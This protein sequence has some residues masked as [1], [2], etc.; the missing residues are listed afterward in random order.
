MAAAA[1]AAAAAQP[2]SG[3]LHHPIASSALA[4]S[5][6]QYAPGM[7]LAKYPEVA[8]FS[9][10]GQ[11][12]PKSGHHPQPEPEQ[13]AAARS[14]GNRSRGTSDSK[15]SY[16]SRHQA[17][18]QRRRTRINE[19]LDRLRTIVPHADRANTAAFLEE[20]INYIQSLQKRVL[21]LDP[22]TSGAAAHLEDAQNVG[23]SRPSAK[24]KAEKR[25]KREVVEEEE[26]DDDDDDDDDAPDSPPRK[27]SG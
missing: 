5:Y 8:L 2:M 10:L 3:G 4:N 1:R 19:R 12:F 21:E 7:Q 17:A 14:G 27:R 16:A 13:E 26:D 25:R 18:E 11:L 9:Q 15:S 6:S 22:K 24:S 23:S 20:V